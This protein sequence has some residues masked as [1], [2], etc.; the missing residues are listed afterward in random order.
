MCVHACVCDCVR[1]CDGA[2]VYNNGHFMNVNAKLH[3][4]IKLN[5]ESIQRFVSDSS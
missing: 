2:Y 1:E 3:M 4:S 5:N